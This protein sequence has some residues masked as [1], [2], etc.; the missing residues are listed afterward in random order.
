MSENAVK[1][2]PRRVL[3]LVL[4][5][6][7][8]ALLLA[9]VWR[10]DN[11]PRTDDA[12]AYADTISVTPE[13]SGSIVE[14]PV[15]ENQQVKQGDVLLRID[16]RPYQDV[17]DQTR[18]SM[19]ALNQEIILSQRQ[20]DAQQ[21]NSDAVQASIE[22]AKATANQTADTLRRMEPL[23]SRGYVSEEQVDQART[24]AKSAR[25][26]LNAAQLQV[27]Q[28]A[29]AVSGVDALVA[30]RAV[31]QAQIARAEL[32]LEHSVVLAPFDGRVVGL[33][34]S[35][36]QFAAAGHPLFS[37]IDTRHW[38][39]VANFRETELDNIQ[40]GNRSTLYLMSDSRR[41]FSGTV[42]SIGFGVFPDDGGAQVSGLPKV[43]RTINWVRVAQRFPVRIRVD[44]PDPQLFRIGASAVAVI[45][46]DSGEGKRQ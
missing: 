18:A 34:T 2:L 16:A 30:R 40:T 6:L 29:A 20:V 24:A 21:F 9:V 11:A 8:V 28:A 37:L 7:T 1:P 45:H 10:L 4:L 36:G 23:L 44:Q 33:T 39:V 22:R 3:I 25:A 38:Y 27:K 32:D 42:D 43:A 31:I 5:G 14:L 41:A 17:L 26:E 46:T 19:Y 15:H 13:V 35:D 12:Y